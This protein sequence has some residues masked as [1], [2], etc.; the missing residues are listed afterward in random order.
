[1]PCA[2]LISP[3]L[4]RPGYA[5]GNVQAGLRN[6]GQLIWHQTSAVVLC[7]LVTLATPAAWHNPAPL[8]NSG[9]RPVM[10]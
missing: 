5:S 1:M 8:P 3:G 6:R 2:W 7:P 9:L 10:V 4:A